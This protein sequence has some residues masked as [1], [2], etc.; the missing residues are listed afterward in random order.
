MKTAVAAAL[1][2]VLLHASPAF[3]E[4]APPVTYE[5]KD[6]AG[7]VVMRVTFH[8][9]GGITHLAMSHGPEAEKLTLESVLDAKREPV[10][11]YREQLDRRGRPVEREEMKIEGG[12]RVT[13]KTKFTYDAQGGRTAETQVIE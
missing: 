8:P 12:R 11:T 5:K 4:G 1:L 9:D 6:D 2:A 3:P 7:R 13:R 10:R